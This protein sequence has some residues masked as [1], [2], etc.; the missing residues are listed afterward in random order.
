MFN[1]SIGRLLEFSLLFA[2]WIF[3]AENAWRVKENAWRV[4]RQ[5]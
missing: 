3:Y 1:M 2:W 5:P 4:N